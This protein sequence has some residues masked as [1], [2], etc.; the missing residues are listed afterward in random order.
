MA[1]LPEQLLK[2]TRVFCRE[3]AAI[4]GRGAWPAWAATASCNTLGPQWVRLRRDDPFRFLPSIRITVT[5]EVEE[6]FCV[7]NIWIF[8]GAV[9]ANMK[10]HR[11]PVG[12]TLSRPELDGWVQLGRM[13]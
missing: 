3:T 8:L 5:K 11:A 6:L 9:L 10:R 1:L 2:R 4:C 12:P 7:V 13:G